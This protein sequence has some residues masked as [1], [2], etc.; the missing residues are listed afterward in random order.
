[1]LCR[2]DKA[3]GS[4]L[5]VMNSERDSELDRAENLSEKISKEKRTQIVDLLINPETNIADF[6]I[7]LFKIMRI[8]LQAGAENL[9]SRQKRRF[10]ALTALG[11]RGG[12][13]K[14]TL[15]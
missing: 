7:P 14:G 10:S 2:S 1:M 6:F 4:I 15:Y 11:L 5:F 9:L 8:G 3:A 12:S 13:T